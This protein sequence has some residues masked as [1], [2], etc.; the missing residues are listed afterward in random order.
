MRTIH[1]I[2]PHGSR[3]SCPDAIG[4]KIGQCLEQHYKV[5]YYNLESP[6]T[7]HPGPDDILVG[8]AIPSPYSIFRRSLNQPGWRRVILITP[9]AH[10]DPRYYA[11]VDRFID[12]CDL[13][14]AITGRYWFQSLKDSAFARWLPKMVHL[15]LAVDRQDFPVLK[16][17]FNPPGKRSFV[18][19][20]I[21]KPYKN[22]G[23]LSGMAGQL[24][25]TR[26][27]WI[28]VGR[29]FPNLKPLGAL[30]FSESEAKEVVRQYDFMITVGNSDPNPTTI[31]EAMA[32]GL[33]PVCTEQSGYA[34]YPGIINL[35]LDNLDEA[36]RIVQ[37]LQ[38][39]PEAELKE[40][41]RVNWIALDEHFNWDRFTRQVQ[42]AIES[43]VSPSLEPISAQ[44]RYY[45][46][47][48]EWLSP[49]AT[50]RRPRHL[51]RVL[52]HAIRQRLALLS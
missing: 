33:I 41:Q 23:Y 35:P 31:L 2:Y 14:L 34:G 48:I 49:Y 1:L 25:N 7:I 24:P 3:I 28:G 30:D 37:R 5:L 36:V 15:D 13:Y 27:N 22:L 19:I 46:R 40:M 32:W 4:R 16:D 8:H 29:S 6:E 9:F 26:I 42:D 51:S 11:F 17:S 44:R 39:C 47:W 43:E 52:A 38:E 20:G 18:Y 10:G 45:L 12:Q 21:Y 50:W